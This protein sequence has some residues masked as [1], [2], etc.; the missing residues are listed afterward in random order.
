MTIDTN[1]LYIGLCVIALLVLALNF[2][3]WFYYR[4]SNPGRGEKALRRTGARVRQP[5]ADEDQK[6]EELSNRVENL[7]N[8]PENNEPPADKPGHHS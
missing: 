4:R 6:L 2:G 3:V 8:D 1:M 5:W 7:K